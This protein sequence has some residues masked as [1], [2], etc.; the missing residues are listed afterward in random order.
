M[1]IISMTS[2]PDKADGIF[3]G[4]LVK[5]QPEVLI[6][7]ASFE[8]GGDPILQP[9]LLPGFYYILAVGIDSDLYTVFFQ[10]F[11]S[12]DDGHQLHAIVGRPAIALR[13]FFAVT[14]PE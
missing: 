9:T 13:E 8:V 5:T 4:Q 11:E 7:F 10:G 14:T 3:F 12:G 6:L 1:R 2:Y